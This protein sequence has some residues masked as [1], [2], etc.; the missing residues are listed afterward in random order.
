M[1]ND[2]YRMTHDIIMESERRDIAFVLFI[3]SVSGSNTGR[4]YLSIE[5][6]E[7]SFRVRNQPN[8]HVFMY[9]LFEQESRIKGMEKVKENV[10]R[11]DMRVVIC[12]GDGSVLWV[13]KEVIEAGVDIHKIVF[14]IIPIGTGNDFS[15]TLGWLTTA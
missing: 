6:E 15:R 14:G 8:V 13:V 1:E 3:N 4:E 5:A 7:I 11:Y 9:D 2:L 12:G 10:D